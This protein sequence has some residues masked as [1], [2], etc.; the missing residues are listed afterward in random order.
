MILPHH[1]A[2]AALAGFGLLWALTIPLTK[3]AVSTGHAPVGLIFWQMLIGAVF[4]RAYLWLRRRPLPWDRIAL[5]HYLVI[6][7]LGTIL[8]N[9]FSYLAAAQLPAGIMAIVVATVP[10]FSLLISLAFAIERFV[11]RRLAGVL[12][13]GLAVVILVGPEASLPEPDKAVFVLVALVA[14]FCYGLEGNYV[15]VKTPPGYDAM[16]T[17]CGASLVG[18]VISG[19]VAWAGGYWVPMPGPWGPAEQAVVASALV[20]ACVYSGYIWLVGVTSAVFASQIA[21]VVTLGGVLL[22]AMLLGERYS[23]W[24]FLALALM[25]AGL[26]LVQPRQRDPVAPIAAR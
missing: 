2:L 25:I 10:M 17:I 8:P 12:L 5:R 1:R 9:S 18:M 22:S 21:Y 11:P 23:L 7:L 13:G 26:V 3:I 4:T 15:A 16:A 20:H 24:V 6:G 19:I 14:P